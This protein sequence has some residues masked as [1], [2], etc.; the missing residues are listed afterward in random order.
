MPTLG[1]QNEMPHQTKTGLSNG[2]VAGATV[3]A[4][5][6][7]AL[8][9][10]LIFLCCWRRKKNQQ[11]NDSEGTGA[12]KRN[13]SVL[14]RSGLLRGSNAEA[15]GPTLP[16]ITT[17]GL[18]SDGGLDSAATG[19]S[20]QLGEMLNRR[21]SRPLF[22][23]ARLNPHALMTQPNFSRTSVSTLQ[24]NQDYSRPLEVRNPDYPR[25]SHG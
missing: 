24:D 22:S 7:A 9:A 15:A 10:A 4:I 18:P 25:L 3:G 1:Q 14:S 12:P 5:A 19:G 16:Q 8:L 21:N 20:S 23:D 11:N 2:A 17:S 13:A 6:G